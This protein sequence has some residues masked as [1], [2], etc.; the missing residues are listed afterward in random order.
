[1]SRRYLKAEQWRKLI[2]EQAGG[3]ES[4]IDFCRRHGLT[5]KSFY[6]RRKALREADQQ[7][8]MVVVAPPALP[9]GSCQ[10][11]ISWKGVELALADSA[12]PAWVA[13]LMRELVDAPVS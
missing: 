5:P 8:A 9:A 10:M 3:T 13:Q 4:V 7:G 2:A 12:S 6:R 1:V 11:A